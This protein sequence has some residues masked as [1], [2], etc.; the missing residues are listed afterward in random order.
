MIPV[1]LASIRLLA[2]PHA[3]RVERDDVSQEMGERWD[4]VGLVPRQQTQVVVPEGVPAPH[5]VRGHHQVAG[6][7]V[8]ALLTGAV[9]TEKQQKWGTLLLHIIS[10]A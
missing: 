3:A 2:L 7:V 5:V 1:V 4:F 8:A 10:L 9:V 6:Q